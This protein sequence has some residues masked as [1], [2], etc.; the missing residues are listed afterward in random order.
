MVWFQSKQYR[1]EGMSLPPKFL[2]SVDPIIV[3]ICHNSSTEGLI[4]RCEVQPVAFLPQIFAVLGSPKPQT[5]DSLPQLSLAPTQN[6]NASL[7]L[8]SS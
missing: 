1:A 4:P 2:D 3:E 7:M 8:L 6:T 5:V